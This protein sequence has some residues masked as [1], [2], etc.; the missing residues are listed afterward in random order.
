VIRAVLQRA[1]ELPE[2]SKVVAVSPDLGE[3]Y[4]RTIYDDAW[5]AEKFGKDCLDPAGD[6]L[7]ALTTVRT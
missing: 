2:G 6:Q 1:P 5:V 7:S 4:A 3:R